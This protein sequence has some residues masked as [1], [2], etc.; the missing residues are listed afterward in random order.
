V[1]EG[2]NPDEILNIDVLQALIDGFHSTLILFGQSNSGKTFSCLGDTQEDG[3]L[4]LCVK[5]AF[6]RVDDGNIECLFSFSACEIWNETVH[7]LINQEQ[8][9]VQ[10]EKTKG[11]FLESR[12]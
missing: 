7:D 4:A 6:H 5:D 9:R 11:F 10:E 2:S 1:A 8:L 3:L 12:F